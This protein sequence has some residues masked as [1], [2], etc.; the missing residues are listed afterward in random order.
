M[1]C[2]MF[3]IGYLRKLL[4]AAFN[5]S[6]P[7]NIDRAEV[8]WHTIDNIVALLIL[9]SYRTIIHRTEKLPEMLAITG[10]LSRHA[11]LLSCS[12]AT[13]IDFQGRHFARKALTSRVSDKNVVDFDMAEA[14]SADDFRHDSPISVALFDRPFSPRRRLTSIGARF[15]GRKEISPPA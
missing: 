14:Q 8:K 6:T 1:Y 2:A 7:L 11:P 10:P 15:C 12:H 13:I 5:I 9:S 3:I 4:D